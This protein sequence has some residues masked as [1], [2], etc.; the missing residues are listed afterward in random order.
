MDTWSQRPEFRESK[1]FALH[2]DHL[3]KLRFQREYIECTSGRQPGLVTP[4]VTG[5]PRT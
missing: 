1:Y 4:L 2:D 5:A 3:E